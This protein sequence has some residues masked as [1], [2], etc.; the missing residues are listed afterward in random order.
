[1]AKIKPNK[2]FEVCK[3]K[4]I[5]DDVV[6]AVKTKLP[7]RDKLSDLADLFMLFGDNTRIGILWALSESEMCV[8]DLGGGPHCMDS[9]SMELSSKT[10]V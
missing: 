7:G 1:V 8:C 4:G 2:K 6:A 5:H 10:A 3:V 9:L